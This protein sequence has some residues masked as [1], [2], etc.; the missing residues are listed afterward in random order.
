MTETVDSKGSI[1]SETQDSE[2]ENSSIMSSNDSSFPFMIEKLNGKNFHEWA[3]S[4]KLIID[5]KGKMEY[6]TG[7]T[8]QPPPANAAYFQ[9][10]KSENSMVISW[11]VNSMMP[12][13]KKT[14]MYLP[15]AKDVW[16]AVRETYSDEGNAAQI[17]EIKT[18][19]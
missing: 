6:L 7:E 12:S 15:S 13:I 2:S 5:G 19:L 14:Y 11:L 4:I 16:D 1:I 17:F 10:W 18:Q 9:K 3:Q 8:K